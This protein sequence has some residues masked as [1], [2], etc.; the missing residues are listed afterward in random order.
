MT[1]QLCDRCHTTFD[2][3]RICPYDGETLHDKTLSDKEIIE[4]IQR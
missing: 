4:Q 3:L 2:G 1:K